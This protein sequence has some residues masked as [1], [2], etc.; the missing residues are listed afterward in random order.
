MQT[1]KGALISSAYRDL[2]IGFMAIIFLVTM[3]RSLLKEAL[4]DDYIR[5]LVPL[6]APLMVVLFA[7]SFRVIAKLKVSKSIIYTLI[8]L[9]IAAVGIRITSFV[10]GESQLKQ[11]FSLLSSFLILLVWAAIIYRMV[12]NLFGEGSHIIEK[13]WASVCIFFMIGIVFGSYYSIVL[14]FNPDSL[15]VA[16][17][18]PMEIYING[19]IYSL[20]VLSGFD[21]VFQNPSDS[22][23]MG[24]IMESLLA[25]LFLVVLLGRLL[26]APSHE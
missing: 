4:G 17:T 13:L 11:I 14:L 12:I 20:N 25:M 5:I 3:V 23:Q 26:G 21:P 6:F 18:H 1:S 9:L 10:I 22:I 7:L 15:G 19:M 8:G 16:M 24:A 2:A